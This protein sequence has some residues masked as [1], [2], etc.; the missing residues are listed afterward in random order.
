MR[1]LR[2]AAALL[3]LASLSVPTTADAVAWVDLQ[4]QQLTFEY[5]NPIHNAE[6]SEYGRCLVDYGKDPQPG[7]L[8]VVAEIPGTGVRAWAVRN[9][10]LMDITYGPP[11]EQ[12]GCRFP[13]DELGVEGGAPIMDLVYAFAVTAEP[14]SDEEGYVFAETTAPTVPAAVNPEVVRFKSGVTPV[15]EMQKQGEMYASERVPFAGTPNHSVTAWMGCYMPNVPLNSG[16]DPMDDSACAP[17]SCANSLQWLDQQHPEIDVP[18]DQRALLKQL[19]NLMNRARG[20][21]A[22]NETMARAKLDFIEAHNLPIHVKLQSLGNNDDIKS[23]SGHT[24]ATDENSMWSSWPTESWLK[25]E[26]QRGEDVE[27]LVSYMYKDATGWHSI[28]GHA[29]VLSGLGTMRDDWVWVAWKHD[30][31]QDSPSGTV[32]ESGILHDTGDGII[33]IGMGG[34]YTKDDGTKVKYEAY[35]DGVLSESFDPNHQQPPAEEDFDDYCDYITRTIKPGGSL[36]LDFPTDK[37]RSFD[38]TVYQVNR[39]QEPPTQ[40]LLFRWTKNSGKSRGVT[41]P[42]DKCITVKFHN[43]DMEGDH[44]WGY[45]DYTVTL[46]QTKTVVSPDPS[47]FEETGGFSL[48]GRDSTCE[49]GLAFAP[50]VVVDYQLGM[51]LDLVPGALGAPGG[52][53]EMFLNCQIPAWNK[54]WGELGFIVD[55]LDVATP[56]DLMVDCLS[57]GFVHIIPIAAPGRYQVQ[58]GTMPEGMP[59]FSLRLEA[60]AGLELTFDALGVPTLVAPWSAVEGEAPRAGLFLAA[61]QPNPF[62]PLT[63]IKFG[64]EEA[65]WARLAVYDLQG[66]RIAL[67]HEGDL[68]AGPHQRSWNGRDDGDREVAAGVYLYRLETKAGELSRKMTLVR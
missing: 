7:F 10:P 31:D 46:S 2:C 43:D 50:T 34:T 45:D 54:Y 35:L 59:D 42:T 4:F 56:G 60:Q 29:V 23:S 57:N 48:G 55:V 49:F 3:V 62:N 22:S 63:D 17:A 19:S 67:L 8:N 24:E 27:L 12:V 58:L 51:Q 1:N 25:S 53:Y 33:V 18:D 52:T 6:F 20:E 21:G 9:V 66:R 37:D 41:N 38:V 16:S 28:G 64:M 39:L 40:Q 14:M 68:R 26:A 61:N 32:Q 5:E 65:G 36:H 44:W 47:N 13:L 15:S 30:T 11:Q